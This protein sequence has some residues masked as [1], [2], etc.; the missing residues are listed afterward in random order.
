MKKRTDFQGLSSQLKNGQL[1][2]TFHF[3]VLTDGG[4]MSRSAY[5]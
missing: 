2:Q 1:V 3:L 5:C 4:S